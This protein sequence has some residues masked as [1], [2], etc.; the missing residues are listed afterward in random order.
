MSVLPRYAQVLLLLYCCMDEALYINKTLIQC[1]PIA[2]L[3][4]MAD[5]YF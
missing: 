2:G 3:N 1:L 5:L 4:A